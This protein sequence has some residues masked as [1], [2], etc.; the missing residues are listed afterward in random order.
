MAEDSLVYSIEVNEKID[1]L[2]TKRYKEYTEKAEEDVLTFEEFVFHIFKIGI[3][4]NEIRIYNTIKKEKEH[5]VG[6]I[7]LKIHNL[8]EEYDNNRK[9]LKYS[10]F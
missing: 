2:L 5:E 9:K 3:L 1:N 10:L 8:T 7:N 6:N 4:H